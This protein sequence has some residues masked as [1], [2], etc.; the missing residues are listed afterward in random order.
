MSDLRLNRGNIHVFVT[1][2][3]EGDEV[4]ALTGLVEKNPDFGSIEDL[5]KSSEEEE[6]VEPE[7]PEAQ[8]AWE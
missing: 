8:Q 3:K 1:L 6:I 7:H 4:K 2:Q 5:E